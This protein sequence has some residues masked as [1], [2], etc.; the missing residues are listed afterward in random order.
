MKRSRWSKWKSRL[1]HEGVLQYVALGGRMLLLAL[2]FCVHGAISL[3]SPLLQLFAALSGLLLVGLLVGWMFRPRLRGAIA[4]PVSVAAGEEFEVRLRLSH[5][6]RHCFDLA[7]EVLDAPSS[8]Q[9]TP[10][11][12]RLAW[13]RPGETAVVSVG[14]RIGR[15]GVYDWPR[16]RLV[17]TF[18]LNLFRFCQTLKVGRQIR[19]TPAYQPLEAFGLLRHGGG[20]QVQQLTGSRHGGMDDFLGNREYQPGLAVRRWDYCSWARL[21]RPVVREYQNEGQ[22]AAA[23]VVDSSFPPAAIKRDTIPELE[24]MLSL[25]AALS[26]AL[27]ARACRLLNVILDGR[28]SGP[29]GTSLLDQ[30]PSL[31]EQ[32]AVVE[33]T[34]AESLDRLLDDLAESR[35][36]PC[37]TLVVLHAWD[38]RRQ[39]LCELLGGG[40]A[41]VVPLLVSHEKPD[42][43]PDDVRWIRPAEIHQ[44]TAAL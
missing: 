30:H 22:F 3:E 34:P 29:P 41:A 21:G 40:G 8:W 28:V 14:M 4:S 11:A 13:L 5:A 31:L 2:L 20:E 15:R 10:P 18:P 35:L 38:E 16:V 26:D 1:L 44:G 33:A 32:L 19:V 6:A 43:L 42:E 36:P 25:A 27:S 24:V 39:R 9:V 37:L 23:L 12:R 7:V 17:S